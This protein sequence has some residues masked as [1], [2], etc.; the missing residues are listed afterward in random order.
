ME[1][2]K[3]MM[4]KQEK[5]M[6]L[7]A[8]YD[9]NLRLSGS[10]KVGIPAHYPPN[11]RD[12]DPPPRPVEIHHAPPERRRRRLSPSRV[13]ASRA[14]L[15]VPHRRRLT[16]DLP[17]QPLVDASAAAT[18]FPG[19]AFLPP[20]ADIRSIGNYFSVQSPLSGHR[21]FPNKNL[22]EEHLLLHQLGTSVCCT[23][24]VI[25]IFFWVVF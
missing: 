18:D 16:S 11:P 21:V 13:G 3:G 25:V 9:G 7:Q 5:K 23:K 6:L 17:E 20:S 12:I 2:E 24:N 1:E 14:A 8:A 22:L 4:G 15:L 19:A 10:G